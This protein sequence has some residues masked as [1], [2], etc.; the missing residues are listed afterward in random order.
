MHRSGKRA[1]DVTEKLS[2]DH[3]LR[4]RSTIELHHRLFSTPAAGVNSVGNHF[5]AHTAFACNENVRIRGRHRP[6]QFLN[7]LHWFALKNWGRSRFRDLEA[8]FQLFRLL[9]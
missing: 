3:C 1:F 9:P 7:L 8:L 5:L 2:L 4:K 6:D